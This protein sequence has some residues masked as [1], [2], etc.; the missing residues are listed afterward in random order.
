[1]DTFFYIHAFDTMITIS[2]IN[3]IIIRDEN[4]TIVKIYFVTNKLYSR[5]ELIFV[6]VTV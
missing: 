4:L 2:I 3:G 5:K 6:V 1:M